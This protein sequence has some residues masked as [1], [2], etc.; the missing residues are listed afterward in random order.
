[1][2]LIFGI[3]SVGVSSNAQTVNCG[4]TPEMEGSIGLTSMTPQDYCFDISWVQENCAPVYIRVNVN[5]FLDD[6]CEGELAAAPGV[7]IDLSP[8]NAFS[9]AEQLID[10]ANAFFETMSQNLLGD[11]DQ[12]HSDVHGAV[13][14]DAQCI[15]FRYVLDRVTVNCDAAAQSTGIN[16]NDFNNYG[17]DE[18]TA[19]NIFVSDVLGG[20][21]GFIVDYDETRTVVENFNPAVLNHEMGHVLNLR[22]TFT[23]DGCDDTWD[24][25][26][27]WDSDCDGVPDV[28]YDRC[29]DNE[30]VHND[31]NACTDF[32]EPHPCCEWSAQNNN[33]MTHSRWLSDPKTAALT[34]CQI[35]R[36]LTDLSDNLCDYVI[37][38]D[39]GCP[40]VNAFIGT[41]PLPEDAVE[42]S[43]CFY[44]EASD[45]ESLYGIEIVDGNGN[46]VVETGQVPGQVGQYCIRPRYD[47]FGNASWPNGMQSG[48]TYTMRLQTYNECGDMDEDEIAFTLPQICEIEPE[49]PEGPTVILHGTSPNPFTDD[50]QV[51]F[52]I[53]EEGML[54][55][56]AMHANSGTYY[57]ELLS[58]YHALGDGKVRHFNLSNFMT[59]ANT[60]VFE[61]NGQL[62]VETII[63]Q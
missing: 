51:F 58:E 38:V 14:T 46:I 16:F 2:I 41:L 4:L 7:S 8:E 13:V 55:V 15:P 24:Y 48:V 25:N 33:L 43:A 53:K 44:M 62:Q 22:H 23:E 57:G 9:V 50:V 1:M 32:C 5:F 52:D 42:C 47:L 11:N 28:F 60:I 26:W 10:D 19:I 39:C 37:H 45:N 35:E 30:P 18:A 34:P 40:P 12:W 59:G 29:F 20:P 63:K 54:K 21:N 56:H 36:M 31:Q 6:N 3:W 49:Q 17:V 61:L 27:E